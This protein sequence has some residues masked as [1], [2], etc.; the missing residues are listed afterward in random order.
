MY[1]GNMMHFCVCTLAVRRTQERSEAAE[2]S[3]EEDASSVEGE[4][5][6]AERAQSGRA[7]SQ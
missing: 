4:G 6:A 5:P 2:G 3:A 7:G 1:K